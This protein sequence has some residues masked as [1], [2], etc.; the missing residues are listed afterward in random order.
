MPP[1]NT[2]P[3]SILADWQ[4]FYVIVGSAAAGLTGL[5]FVVIALSMNF[6]RTSPAGVRAYVTPTV[7]HF[8]TVLG[9]A[10]VLCVPRLSL[11]SLSFAMGCAGAAGFIYGTTIG[12]N[13]HRMKSVYVPV[14]EDWVWHMGLPTVAYTSLLG[15]GVLL[16]RRPELSL[17]GIAAVALLLLFIGIHNAWDVAISFTLRAPDPAAG[18]PGEAS[19]PAE[20]AER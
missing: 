7:V 2:P 10:S 1:S 6:R 8:G 12:M 15:L 11:T 17:D 5:T 18:G 13:M 3:L 16:H 4:N 19:K 20:P 14:G 9:L